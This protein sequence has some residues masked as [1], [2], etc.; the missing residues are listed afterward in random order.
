MDR[1]LILCALV[2]RG[3][4]RGHTGILEQHPWQ[5]RWITI[6]KERSRN[7]FDRTNYAFWAAFLVRVAYLTLAHTYRIRPFP[8]HFEYG[9]EM[10]RIARALVTGHGYADPFAGHTGPTAWVTPLYP[11]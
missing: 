8:D 9:W 4:F 1:S 5:P 10:G 6:R 7:L 3:T 11:L 2:S